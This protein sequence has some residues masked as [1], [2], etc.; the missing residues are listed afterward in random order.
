MDGQDLVALANGALNAVNAF[1]QGKI[2][3]TGDMSLAMQ[4]QNILT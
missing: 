3:V 4:L 1:M 2:K